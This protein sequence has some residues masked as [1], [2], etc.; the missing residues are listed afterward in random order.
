MT[1]QTGTTASLYA[2]NSINNALGF[3]SSSSVTGYSA[4]NYNNGTVIRFPNSSSITYGSNTYFPFSG[5]LQEIRYYVPTISA[6]VFYDY[7]LNPYSSEGNSINS[8][9]NEL[10]FR[11]DL[12]TIS[13]TGSRE[14][15][16][17]KVS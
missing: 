9:P 14:S 4:T 12:G 6:S 17:P 1:T 3:V 5:S 2:A 15:I 10:I 11:A 8:S 7:V 16:H 13:D